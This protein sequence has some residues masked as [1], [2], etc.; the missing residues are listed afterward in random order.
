MER[1]FGDLD[2]DLQ[3]RIVR[4][5]SLEDAGQLSVCNRKLYEVV[6]PELP[7]LTDVS[8]ID[9]V[10]SGGRVKLTAYNLEID[11]FHYD[12]SLNCRE[13]KEWILS[14]KSL[15]PAP[16]VNFLIGKAIAIC[17]Y[18]HTKTRYTLLHHLLRARDQEKTMYANL[19]EAKRSC[20]YCA[21]LSVV[22]KYLKREASQYIHREDAQALYAACHGSRGQ[23]VLEFSEDQLNFVERE[24][25]EPLT[26]LFKLAARHVFCGEKADKGS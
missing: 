23:N 20:R 21:I 1:S 15:L 11:V 17:P 2:A 3:L 22:N 7:W 16:V 8:V 4:Y 12:S 6:S 19:G 5:C 13:D 18:T 25:V 10:C 14:A 26:E 9:I 24:R